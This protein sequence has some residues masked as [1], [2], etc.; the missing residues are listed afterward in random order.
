MPWS[1][2]SFSEIQLD[3]V[4]VI[5]IINYTRWFLTENEAIEYCTVNNREK[6]LPPVYADEFELLK[7]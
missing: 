1:I 6:F 3:D 7:E 4:T 2:T 5:E